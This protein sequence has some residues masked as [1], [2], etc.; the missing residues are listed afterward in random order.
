MSFEKPKQRYKQVA[1]AS[2][3]SQLVSPDSGQIEESLRPTLIAERCGK[4][5]EGQGHWIVWD[6]ARQGLQQ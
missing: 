2:S 4:R 3:G 5:R 6:C 1:I